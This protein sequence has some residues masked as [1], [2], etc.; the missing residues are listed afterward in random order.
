MG[1]NTNMLQGDG[2]AKGGSTDVVRAAGAVL[3]PEDVADVVA[4]AIAAETFLIA[5][6]AEVLTFW[7]RKTTDYDRWIAG[8]RRLQARVVG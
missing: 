7:Q 8:M 2:L 1:V 5:P 3:E 6:H 4:Q